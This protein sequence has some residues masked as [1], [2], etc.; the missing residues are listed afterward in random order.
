VP[1]SFYQIHFQYV[2]WLLL[3]AVKAIG[4]LMDVPSHEPSPNYSQCM[5]ER[6]LAHIM[7]VVYR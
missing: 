1:I 4:Q 6:S 7:G 3:S 5:S 2:T